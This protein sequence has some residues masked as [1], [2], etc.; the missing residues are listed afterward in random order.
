MT[1]CEG[2]HCS[3]RSQCAHHGLYPEG[4]SGQVIDYSTEG[5][6]AEGPNGTVLGGYM[7]GDRNYT[8]KNYKN[9]SGTICIEECLTCKYRSLCSIVLEYAGMVFNPGDHIRFDCLK[10]KEN[11]TSYIDRLRRNGWGHVLDK[12]V[13]ME[14][15]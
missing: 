7:C 13:H 4:A 9:S 11:P 12:H 3:I 8:Y 5:S 1:Y 10:I 2:K 15:W 14:D 6:H